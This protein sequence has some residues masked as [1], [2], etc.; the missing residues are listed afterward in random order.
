MAIKKFQESTIP[1]LYVKSIE[2]LGL[3]LDANYT[4]R[5]ADILFTSISE[6]LGKI[7]STE[8]PVAFIF[9]ELNGNFIAGAVVQYH[10]G[11][12][13]KDPGNYSYIWTFDKSDIP[14]GSVEVRVIDQNFKTFFNGVSIQKYKMTVKEEFFVNMIITL[15]KDISKWLDDNAAEGDITGIELDGIFQA[16]VAVEGGEIVKSMEVIGDTKALIKSDASIEK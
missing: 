7:K 13:D 16:R 10:A 15:M 3:V 11:K 1:D 14:D 8:H 12:G 6:F 9:D 2:K 5:I 4:E